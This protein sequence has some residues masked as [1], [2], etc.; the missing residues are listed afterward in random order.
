ML[1]PRPQRAE[2]LEALFHPRSLVVVGAGHD[3]ASP[4][5]RILES[6][7][8]H[9]YAGAVHVVHPN[10]TSVAGVPAVP[11]ARLVQPTPD[12][13]IVAV[14]AAHVLAAIDD[15]GQAGIR[16]VLLVSAGFREAGPDGAALESELAAL[17]ARHRMRL[18]GPNCL[19][20]IT[21]GART[22]L[23]AT[24]APRPVR[25][26][27][28]A[29]MTQSGAM[30]I[31]LLEHAHRVRLGVSRFVSMGNKLDVS[32]NDLLLLWEDDP[33]VAMVLVY[34]ESIGNPRNFLRI[35]R[36]VGAKKPIVVLKGGRSELGAKA[37]GSHTGALLDRDLLVDALVEQCGIL[38]AATVEQLF[39]TA[40]MLAQGRPMAGNR[41]AIV[42]QSGGPAILATDA[43]ESAGL[44]LAEL[45]AATL[46]DCRA[47]LPAAAS[48][49]NPMDT[50]AG[51]DPARFARVALRVAQDPGV[52]ALLL[53]FTPLDPDSTAVATALADVAAATPKPVAA[54]LFGRGPDDPGAQL[55][56]DRGCPAFA[57]PENAVRS[58]A[59]LRLLSVRR[60]RLAA[61]ASA[62][63]EPTHAAQLKGAG[64]LAL[65]EALR[66]AQRHGIAVPAWHAF[67]DQ[68]SAVDAARSLEGPA[69][70]KFDIDGVVHKSEAG[71]VV[72]GVQGPE[73]VAQAVQAA[74]ERHGVP[75][76]GGVA[77]AM[78]A[79]GLELLVGGLQDPRYGPCVAVGLGGIHAEVL[80]DTVFRLAPLDL[81]EAHRML[82]SLRGA[83]LLRGVRG[84]PAV[85]REALARTLVA[86]GDL[87]AAHPEVLEAELNPV[88]ARSDGAVAVDV[89]VRL[90][91]A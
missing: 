7:R 67:T 14:P 24:F 50:L 34:L 54:T 31:A 35:A 19:G 69:A 62:P 89:R 58:L 32:G 84:A 30:G 83:A 1:Q 47:M 28:T 15:C 6:I 74:Q 91:E 52:D 9:G 25:P 81:A 51:A 23:H 87:L 56:Q 55:L 33:E 45:D 43:L 2:G 63:A 4:G 79:P 3:E 80:R 18:V 37:A 53:L 8:T 90:A 20:I 5:R 48:V 27:R 66:L 76:R 13:A 12:L 11:S 59:D 41:V 44:R 57:F 16:A 82:D 73:A 42:T 21:Q 40:T 71:A 29:I 61:S 49:T 78:A 64:W 17:L 38:R 88:L 26:G 22:R 77:M 65:P 39:D 85:D 10:Q 36:R 46:A 75:W 72:L 68:A 60:L 70:L 86:L